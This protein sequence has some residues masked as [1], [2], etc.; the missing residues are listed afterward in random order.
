MTAKITTLKKEYDVFYWEAYA[1]NNDVA[2]VFQNF[3]ELVAAKYNNIV[4]K[5]SEAVLIGGNMYL[6]NGKKSLIDIL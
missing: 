1:N 3:C 2:N 5:P 4:V 6:L